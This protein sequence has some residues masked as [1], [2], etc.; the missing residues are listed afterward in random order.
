MQQTWFVFN[1]TIIAPRCVVREFQGHLAKII[2]SSHAR[3]FRMKVVMHPGIPE[4]RRAKP[5][6]RPFFY[7]N[8][9]KNFMKLGNILVHYGAP[10]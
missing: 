1:Q 3:A 6:G 2:Q 7:H 9:I 4:G 8:F 5:Q 10:P